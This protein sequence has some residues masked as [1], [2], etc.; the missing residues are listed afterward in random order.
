MNQCLWFTGLPC[1]GKTT[2]VKALEKY[3][4]KCKI[5]DGDEVRSTPLGNFAG[6]SKQNRKDHIIRMGYLAQM[7]LDEGYTVLC[8]FVSPI[9][10][11][12]E[13][14][15]RKIGPQ[16]TE[17]Y[18]N[19]SVDVCSRRDVKGM[20]ALAY[21]GHMKNFTGV[22]APY[23]PPINPELTLDTNELSVEQCLNQIFKICDPYSDPCHLFPGRWNGVFHNGHDYII[24]QKVKTGANVTLAVR[25][26]KPDEKNPWTA[27]EVKA[28]LE[29]RFKAYPNVNIIIIPDIKSVE[30]GRGVGYE[31]NQIKVTKSIAG[32]SGTEC[33]EMIAK[34][35]NDWK[36]LVPKEIAEYL[37]RTY[38]I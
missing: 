38:K 10:E 18:L 5:L 1:S 16:F 17:I 21:E 37:N 34:G 12:R 9:R 26:I 31:V 14:L 3:Y 4:P 11:T 32:I 33:R 7:F 22:T 25:N 24:M 8:S 2:L 20:Y 15:R 23:E 27:K 29:Y 6:F 28:M 13:I 30:Y 35:N 36:K 19:T